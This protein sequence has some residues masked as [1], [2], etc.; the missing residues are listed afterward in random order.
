MRRMALVRIGLVASV[1]AFLNVCSAHV[2]SSGGLLALLGIRR[3]YDCIRAW[4]FPFE[5]SRTGGYIGYDLFDPGAL[6]L[7]VAIAVVVSVVAGLLWARR[8]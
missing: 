6:L 4:G 3:C 2:R 8:R 7:D 5:V 1:L